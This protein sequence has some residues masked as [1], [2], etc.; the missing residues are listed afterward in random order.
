METLIKSV[1][2]SLNATYKNQAFT[3]EQWRTFLSETN[4]IINGRPLYPSSNDIWESPPITP[5]DILIGHH[6]PLPQPEPEERINP[7]HLLRSTQ[8]RVNEFWK[9]WMRYFAP[10]LLPRN[11]WFRTRENVHVDRSS[12]GVGSEPQKV[13]VE[14]G[15]YHCHVS[16]KGWLG[17]KG[18]NQDPG[19]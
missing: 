5:N 8:D 11:K 12:F 6:L 17:Q 7:R 13:S 1:R 3:E 16:R 2:Q 14:V 19:W 15:A 4:Y 9:C 18:Q 10:N